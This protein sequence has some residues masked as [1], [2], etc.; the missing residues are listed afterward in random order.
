MPAKPLMALSFR[1][2]TGCQWNQL[3]KAFGDDSSVHRTF[4]RWENLG[5]FDMLWAVL[6]H[7]LPGTRRGRLA[8]AIRRWLLGQSTRRTQAGRRPGQYAG[9]KKGGAEECVGPN[10]TDR[11]K[12][13]VKKSLLVEGNGRP[14]AAVISGANTPRLQ[15]P[16]RHTRCDCRRASVADRSRATASVFGQGLR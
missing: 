10:P 3:P 13:G 1:M 14:L 6:I 2:R 4:Q 15:T 8:M 16:C 5:L 12:S 11:G 7:F 9:R